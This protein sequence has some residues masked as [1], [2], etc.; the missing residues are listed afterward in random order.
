[1]NEQIAETH[2]REKKIFNFLKGKFT[3]AVYLVL[4]A[5]IWVN[6]KIRT[7]PMR[8][9]PST[10][11]PFL[12]DVTRN[13]WT[14][15]PDLDPFFFLRWAKIIVK[16]GALPAIDTFRYSPLGYDTMLETKI[17]PYLISYFYKFL[18]LFSSGVT[19]EYAAVLL[20]VVGSVFTALAF[21]ILVRKIFENKGIK[22]SNIISL[23]STAFFVTLPSM[24]PR[25]IAG[26]PEKESLGFGLMFLTFYFFLCAWKSKSN[27]KAGILGVLAGLTT[28]IMALVWGGV[29]FV[30]VVI[31]IA[32]FIAL[33]FEKI[34]KKELIVYS[35]WIV[36]TMFIWFPFT[37]R[38]SFREF[39]TSSTGG[40]ALIVWFFLIIYWLVFKTKIKD[41]KILNSKRIKKI[42]SPIQAIIISLVLIFLLYSIVLGPRALIDF[43]KDIV[44]KL[45][46]PYADRLAFTVAENKQPFFS[47]WKANF[48]PIVKNIPVFFWLF[49]AGTIFLFN[50]MI[51]PLKKGKPILIGGYVLFLLAIIFSRT[52]AN[53]IMNG[54]NFLSLLVYAAG[55][56]ILA[57][58]IYHILSRNKEEKSFKQINFEYIFL[59]SL[60]FIGIIA[61]RSGIR[62]IM[63]LAPIAV[64]PIS[65]MFVMVF[66][67]ATKKKGDALKLFF[68]VFASI[69]LVTV[70][71][72]LYY[73]YKVSESSAEAMV[74]SSY[75]IEWQKAMGWVREN[76]P[77]DAVFG[78]WWDYGYWVQT[79]GERATMLDGGNTI[80]YWDY[81]M[82][83]HVLT[84]ETEEEALELL[85]NHNV[86][87]FLIDSTEIGKYGAY[88]SIG[89][90]ENYDRLSW[91]G[92]FV[93]DESQI[94][95][96]K[97]KTILPYFGGS[98]VDEDII[99]NNGTT[100][101]PEKIAGIGAI[102]VPYN[103]EGTF[104]QPYAIIVYDNTQY[105]VN[106]RYIYYK[107]T[108][109]DFGSGVEGAAYIFT[110]I[111]QGPQGIGANEMGAVMYLS[112]KN[113]RALWVRLYLLGEEN[114]FKLVHEESNSLVSDLRRG[115]LNVPE[116][117][118]FQGVRGPI[119]I[120]E[121]NYTGEERYNEEYL[122]KTY[123]E[124]IKDRKYQ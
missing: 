62:L 13:N 55:Y 114:H 83:R 74:P 122:M 30:L 60:I 102:I 19:V 46:S 3:W 20:P 95:E 111:V 9:N 36:S 78:H 64:I 31:A 35:T 15:G 17:L 76:T 82:G 116:I 65:Y 59:F 22:I 110:N 16:E 73:N 54:T 40:T 67:K 50:D 26:I 113:L 101:F 23:I 96:T 85:Y 77:T 93:L 18:N 75:T 70:P 98:T 115:G 118:F 63:F 87:H 6:I 51:K 58:S 7:L 107:G 8:I 24:I 104:S 1:M 71:Y 41:F 28:A 47:T 90:D 108:L 80:S 69:L 29:I 57:Y 45:T 92:T 49:F 14:L 21:F 79:M 38:M 94:E 52:G 32:A 119:K 112:P 37:L 91:I 53:S 117:V 124:R 11:T 123:P 97:N 88:S 39:L 84:A 72:T 121:V 42:P 106:L 48:G 109:N 43:G 120:W 81:L 10:G 25:T 5:I 34:G 89:S 66:I 103:K 105:N 68:L 86:T 4:T 61:A 12:W 99:I 33:L 100:I 27:M 2:E 56:L 44:A